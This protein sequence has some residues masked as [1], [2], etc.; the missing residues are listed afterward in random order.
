M[1]RIIS[2][3][4]ICLVFLTCIDSWCI[5]IS[6]DLNEVVIFDNGIVIPQ[7]RF[8]L[9]R[10][11]DNY[12]AIKFTKSTVKDIGW[13]LKYLVKPGAQDYYSE[14]D[15]Y[16]SKNTVGSFVKEAKDKHGLVSQKTPR[17]FARLT[18]TFDNHFIEYKTIK[19]FWSGGI[20]IDDGTFGNVVY[21]GPGVDDTTYRHELAPTPWTNIKD[22]N[23]N[24]PRLMWYKY[25][26]K[27]EEKEI[28]IDDLFQR[29]RNELKTKNE[30]NPKK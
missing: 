27:R 25:D 30:V 14:Y 28:S 3:I 5:T 13:Y 8:I 10:Y 29:E 16:Y 4:I 11:N 12:I 1:N 21:F 15:L 9:Y 17:G 18:V 23:F 6:P 22:V 7:N 20:D 26:E 19:I 24:D 2:I